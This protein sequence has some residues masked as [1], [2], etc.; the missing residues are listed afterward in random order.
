MHWNGKQGWWKRYGKRTSVLPRRATI[1]RE[2]TNAGP[3]KPF[4]QWHYGY[5]CAAGLD[6][7]DPATDIPVRRAR[8]L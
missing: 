6:A 3:C 7:L 2:W 4:S 5:L 8:R 1:K